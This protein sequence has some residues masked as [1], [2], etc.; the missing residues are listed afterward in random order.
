MSNRSILSLIAAA[1]LTGCGGSS[2][3]DPAPETPTP[4]PSQPTST[5]T[6]TTGVIT[7][8]G[9]VFVNGVEYETD[10]TTV[11]TDDND[12][13]SETNLQ[14][15][16][17]VNLSGEVNEDGTTG[18]A[19][20]IHYDEQLKGPMDSIDLFAN[21][22]IILGQTILFDD[23]TSLENFILSDLKPG[24]ILEI[25]GYFNADG[26]LY[27]TRIEKENEQTQL[28]IQARITSLD[29]V[30]KT[31]ELNGLTIDY[32]SATFKDF[33]EADLADGQQ[34]RVKG[35]YSALD[36]GVLV[37][38]EVK[39]KE[40]NENHDE[41]DNRHVEGF[42][43]DFESSSSFKVDGIAIIIDDNTEF[44]YGDASALMANVR[45]KIK[46][47]F[48]AD[49]ALLAKKIRIE[50][51]TNLS[52]EGA[53]EAINLELSTVTVLGV[54]FE[55]NNQTKMKDESDDDE[56]FFD[57][58][59]LAIGDYV[60]LKGFVDS[61]GKN[62]ATKMKRENEDENAETELKGKVSNIEN[63]SFSLVG[64]TVTTDANTQFE[65]TN[66]DDVSQAVFFEQLENDMLVEVKGQLIDSIFV[67]LKVEIEEHDDDDDDSN[68]NR[69][70]FKGVVEAVNEDSLLVSGHQVL[71][72]QTAKFKVDDERVS[73]EQFWS[74][75][76]ID[77]QLEIK[78]TID[79]QGVITAKSIE[80]E[81]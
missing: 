47:E 73:A 12:G 63:F 50:H 71:T 5:I 29:T 24:D 81:H 74:I 40:K 2:T 67:A 49:G 59:D 46:G 70:E 16:M 11:T 37:V 54:E 30:N 31:F 26:E 6:A 56:R 55:I 18:D 52:I 58:A 22:I 77:D 72:S 68:D 35:E 4:T 43:T 33:V 75:V 25:S 28:K 76:A 7:G 34:V 79:Q 61:E 8:F 10:A 41:G 64:V 65:G 36:A 3:S 23:L 57:L 62:I 13:A 80:L 27:A 44:K 20:T 32:S 60:E 53:I 9:S 66:G 21:T 19:N 51:K 14:V 48:N 78:G 1:I 69:T 17:V 15:G 42:I 39:L 45:V 38:S